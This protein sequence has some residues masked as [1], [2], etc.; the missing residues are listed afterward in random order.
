MVHRGGAAVGADLASHAVRLLICELAVPMAVVVDHRIVLV[1][2]ALASL[3]GWSDPAEL[4]GRPLLDLVRVGDA[5]GVR[6]RLEQALAGEHVA[7]TQVR[8]LRADGSDVVVEGRA[9]PSRFDGKPALLLDIRD[10][11]P[12]IDAEE[13]LRASEARWRSLVQHGNDLIVVLDEGLSVAYAS[14]SA[15]VILAR[16]PGELVGTNALDL[17]HPDDV[18]VALAAF[19]AR[20]ADAGRAHKGARVRARTG[21]NG[22][23]WLDTFATNLLDDPDVAGVI[24]NAWDVTAQVE[25]EQ[26]LLHLARHDSLTGLPNRVLLTERLEAALSAGRLSGATTGL[27]MLDLD[28]F[29]DVNDT[30]GHESGDRV[31][32]ELAYR[33]TL[34]VRADDVVGR[35]GGD[36]FAVVLPDA[37]DAATIEAVARRILEACAEPVVDGGMLL[38]VGASIGMVHA[39]EHGDEGSLLLRRVDAAMYRAKETRVG[40]FAA[41]EGDLDE[42]RRRLEF[43]GELRSALERGELVCEY[44]PKCSLVDGR[45]VGF[46]ALVHWDHP[47]RGRVGPDVFLPDA[48]HLGLMGPLTV[49]VLGEALDLLAGWSAP[50]QDHLTMAVNVSATVLHDPRFVD[51]VDE[52]LAA[53][54]A[55]PTRLVLEVTEQAA[56]IQP[57]V[58]IEAMSALR[59][60]GIGFSIDD[61][62]TGQSSLTYLRLLPVQEVKIDRSFIAQL[63]EGTPEAAIARSVVDLAHN[64]G[65]TALA[66]GIES[67][68]VLALLRS[69]R[70]DLGQGWHLGRPVPASEVATWGAPRR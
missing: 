43:A 23:R 62:G 44:Q 48:E 45:V 63:V 30:L 21:G 61:F 14:P 1:N 52:A 58:S 42:G 53:S 24:V 67:E 39:P 38:R 4:E 36:E 31:L 54:G 27:L 15:R 65:M 35:I 59:A 37:G 68:A 28:R 7:P 51:M 55:D 33:L 64:L 2:E 3:L 19:S 17:L 60:R 49:L 16:D 5:E 18:A 9:T 41:F 20:V 56:M 8:A 11:T 32:A 12:R 10:L 66:E 40:V 29:K 34:A 6:D 25:H 26:E 13:A 22:W 70:C 69:Y 46:E 50:G 57:D 47:T